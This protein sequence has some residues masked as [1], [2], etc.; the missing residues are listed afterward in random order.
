[1][2][3]EAKLYCECGCG[4][5]LPVS[6][7]QYSAIR[8]HYASGIALV[9]LGECVTED[10]FVFADYKSYQIIASSTIGEVLNAN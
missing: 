10:H 9:V 5:Y 3:E 4:E 2:P 8:R 1:M 7:R 6:L